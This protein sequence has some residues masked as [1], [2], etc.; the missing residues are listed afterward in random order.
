M[1]WFRHFI[2]CSVLTI[3]VGIVFSRALGNGFV[4]DDLT[5]TLGNPVYR[6]FLLDRMLLGLANGLEYLPVRDVSLALDYHIWGESPGGFHASS[7]L[8]Y[9]GVCFA[10]YWATLVLAQRFNYE[11]AEWLAGTTALLFGL[12]PTHAETVG[13]LACRNVLL[14][15]LFTFLAVGCYLRFRDDPTHHRRL[16]FASALFCFLLAVMSKATGITLPLAL[17]GIDLLNRKIRRWHTLVPLVPFFLLAA[18]VFILFRV[19]AL[20]SNI[21][22]HGADHGGL[23]GRLA[24]A[25]QIPWFYLGKLTLPVGLGTEYPD[26]FSTILFSPVP[27]VALTGLVT[28]LVILRW[29]GSRHSI[30]AVATIWFGSFLLPILNF[31]QTYPVVADRYIF[32]SSYGFALLV[33]WGLSC[34]AAARPRFALAIGIILALYWGSVSALRLPVWRTELSYWQDALITNPESVK[35]TMAIGAYY[36]G[37]GQLDQALGY[38]AQARSLNPDNPMYDYALGDHELRQGNPRAAVPHLLRA[39]SRKGDFTMALLDLGDA[40]AAL[41]QREKAIDAYRRI[42]TS[43]DLDPQGFYKRS[44]QAGLQKLKSSP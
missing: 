24:V 31:F 28:L 15:G 20:T 7:L 5:M 44:A 3:A 26:R 30:P 8:I 17:L 16:W 13:M 11:R 43:T 4:G 23:L 25:L 6:D 35:A 18:A 22:G 34:M 19:I 39:L 37:V 1:R 38:Y 40:Y 33:A 27:L 2:S 41:G 14:S 42:F 9:L 36:Y 12:H 21:F 10:V 29:L 32:L